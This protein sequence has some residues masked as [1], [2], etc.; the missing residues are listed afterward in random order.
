MSCVLFYLRVSTLVSCYSHAQHVSPLFLRPPSGC[1]P[2]SRLRPLKTKQTYGTKNR[3]RAKTKRRTI[4]CARGRA[5]RGAA[6]RCPPV[7]ARSRRSTTRR[8][9]AQHSRLRRAR[10]ARRR[11]GSGSASGAACAASRCGTARATRRGSSAPPRTRTSASKSTR[12]CT[13]QPYVRAHHQV[14]R[15]I[16]CFCGVF[17]VWGT[18]LGI[19]MGTPKWEHRLGTPILVRVVVVPL[20]NLLCSLAA[21]LFAASS[22]P[23]GYLSRQPRRG[24]RR[25]TRGR[26]RRRG[27]S[28]G[29]RP[30]RR[31]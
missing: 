8:S 6:G 3:S 19:P 12:T 23:A 21:S 30:L 20:G 2:H 18:L 17:L 16:C 29:E 15:R 5:V 4:P 31:R 9:T 1:F 25:R 10:T 7:R 26:Q 14:A 13:S 24:V 22:F 11:S 27:E 28:R